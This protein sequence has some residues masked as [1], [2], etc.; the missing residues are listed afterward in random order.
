MNNI[1]VSKKINNVLIMNGDSEQCLNLAKQFSN[2]SFNVFTA[3]FFQQSVTKNSNHIKKYI[4]LPSARFDT[5]NFVKELIKIVLTFKIDLIIPLYDVS[6]Y[7][8]KNKEIISKYTTVFVDDIDKLKSLHNKY[9]FATLCKNYS[10][11]SPSF[12]L[13]KNEDDLLNFDKNY[14]D[15][16][17]KPLA[18]RWGENVVV[19]PTKKKLISIINKL[20]YPIIAQQFI[21]GE[22]FSTYSISRDGFVTAHTSYKSIYKLGSSGIAFQKVND[23]KIKKFVS[24]FCR[25]N[26][27]NGQIG[28]DFIKDRNGKYFVI[29]CNP[30]AT[31]GVTMFSASINLPQAFIETKPVI[32]ADLDYSM[33]SAAMLV[34]EL[35]KSILSAKVIHFIRYFSKANDILCDSKDIVPPIYIIYFTF[36]LVPLRML[37][38]QKSMKETLGWNE[39]YNI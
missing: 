8:S 38:L 16:V 9:E 28:F 4:R 30:R 19:K 34:I 7:L 3:D 29:E 24:D 10:I 33:L 25:K 1:K 14:K 39:E 31:S 21:D 26:N 20:R 13:I 35:P 18:S 27:Y 17:F 15:Y 2:N 36:V 22:E 11:S 37:A 5:Q 32:S 6:F 12:Q 23:D